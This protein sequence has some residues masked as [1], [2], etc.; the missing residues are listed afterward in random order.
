[1]TEIDTVVE[2]DGKDVFVFAFLRKYVEIEEVKK[3]MDG[4]V[5]REFKE[6]PRREYCESCEITYKDS[7]L[8]RVDGVVGIAKEF[9]EWLVQGKTGQVEA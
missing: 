2:S 6:N 4:G 3:Y 1:M 9:I 7:R 8:V 5:E